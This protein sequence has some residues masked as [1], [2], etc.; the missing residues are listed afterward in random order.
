MRLHALLAALLLVP[1]GGQSHATDD[2]T[3][4][5]D[6]SQAHDFDGYGAH[7]WISNQNTVQREQ[8]IDELRYRHVRAAGPRP[9]IPD[10]ELSGT[11]HTVAE[12]LD[13]FET[14]HQLPASAID[15]LVQDISGTTLHQIVWSMPKPWMTLQNG[16]ATCWEANT[17]HLADYV[18]LIVAEVLYARQYGMNATYV[19]LTNEPD[20]NWNTYWEPEDYA[21]LVEQTRAALDAHGLQSVGIEGPGTGTQR[22]AVAYLEALVAERAV[23]SL[24]AISVHDYDTSYTDDCDERPC[25]E[26]PIGLSD[27]FQA[28]WDELG[29]TLP[30]HV[31]EY[32]NRDRTKWN[33]APYDCSDGAGAGRVNGVCALNTPVYGLWLAT[34]GLKLA[35]DGATAAIQW[36]LQDGPWGTTNWGLINVSGGFRPAY[37]AFKPF[38]LQ[39]SGDMTAVT[40]SPSSQQTV[41]A[42]FDVG[43]DVVVV[44]SNLTTSAVTLTPSFAGLSQDT[45]AIE[46][47]LVYRVSTG[48]TAEESVTDPAT[49]TITVP[50]Q[51]LVAVRFGPST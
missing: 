22:N 42:A 33:A 19:E 48:N 45:S 3:T 1:L 38:L 6:F 28:A 43:S 21:D 50:G 8:A 51:S 49:H 31:T 20:G 16:C 4:V 29:L 39:L 15:G 34:E 44:V 12:L 46:R 27:E 9:P 14:Y 47:Q 40:G 7:V 5:Y 25:L 36:E 11:G 24:D 41:T 10:S 26:P 2:A 32:T 13:L 17:A 23:G 30:I 37:R 18:N 35:A